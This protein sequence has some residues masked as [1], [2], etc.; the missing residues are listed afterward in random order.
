MPLLC[1]AAAIAI[2]TNINLFLVFSIMALVT[3]LNLSNILA[4]LKIKFRLNTEDNILIFLSI[5]IFIVYFLNYSGPFL[6]YWDTY[7]AA[8]AI[9]MTGEKIDFLALDNSTQFNYA[10]SN[11]LPDDL[12][13]KDSYGIITKDREIGAS[14]VFSIPF[15]YFSFFGFRLF[16]CFFAVS[17]FLLLFYILKEMTA[18][19]VLSI[20]FSLILMLNNYTLSIMT[21]NPN[22]IG[23]SL[24]LVIVL[25]LV[26]SSA[27]FPWFFLGM[28]Y[29]MLG[30]T[31]NLALLFLPALLFRMAFSKKMLVSI[32]LFG[33]GAFIVVS[34]VLYW[35]NFA[36]GNILAHPSQYSGFE[37]YRPVFK[38]SFLGIGFGFNGLL[39]F[40]FYEKI[41]R[42]PHYPFPVFIYLPLL[43]I[44]IFGLLLVSLI[45]LGIYGLLK[46]RKKDAVFLCLFFIPYFAFLLFQENW[47]VAKTTFFILAIPG[48]LFF[49][50]FGM[51]ELLKLAY[52]KRNSLIY[53]VSFII[54][55]L[56]V[57]LVSAHDFPADERWYQRFPKA[58][59]ISQDRFDLYGGFDEEWK[60]FQLRENQ[61]NTLE[62]K[63]ELSKLNLF[64]DITYTLRFDF[65]TQQI[66]DELK[67]D[68]LKVFNV[69]NYIYTI[70]S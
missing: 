65:D 48:M 24:I 9:I 15:L 70:A 53:I 38:H 17:F 33:I 8:P 30:T 68:N 41:I 64:P 22:M 57:R 4:V 21:L 12:I 63:K 29:G 28:L 10:L 47:E 39:N 50:A 60:F 5:F 18:S 35:N 6:G 52:F 14:I 1:F 42:T 56:A 62:Q 34:P 55:A 7:I 3:G 66:K 43:I 26:K 54:L 67:K 20:L 32:L 2:G 51:V 36:F 61:V 23:L 49:M 45:P 25:A 44:R 37:G 69:W 46:K 40:P 19:S 27:N 13:K 58:L 11:K 16:Y 31:R 59:N